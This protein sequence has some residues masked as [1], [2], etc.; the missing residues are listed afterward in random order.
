MVFDQI[1][2]D[3]FDSEFGIHGI[4]LDSTSLL[5]NRLLIT[6]EDGGSGLR[7]LNG[8]GLLTTSAPLQDFVIWN[9]VVYL[10]NSTFLV[11]GTFAIQT[12]SSQSPATPS[13]QTVIAHVHYEG[14][15]TAPQIVRQM[16]GNG[17]EIHSIHATIEGGAVA[18][19][20]EE[21]YIVSKNSVQVLPLSLIHI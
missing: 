1:L 11:T 16:M 7:G 18:A 6:S 21:F 3:T 10:G 17:S 13:P 9:K 19:T 14:D 4:A 20:N 8:Y 2:N 12:S 15:S 5:N